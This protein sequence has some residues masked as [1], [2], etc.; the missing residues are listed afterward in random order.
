MA[1]IKG[2]TKTIDNT[3]KK[4]LSSNVIIGWSNKHSDEGILIKIT[5][6]GNYEI[7][8]TL[9]NDFGVTSNLKQSQKNV[10]K[11]MKAHPKG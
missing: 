11:Y 2:W 8:D 7:V 9:G 1:R 4:I 6:R 5:N 3:N 10:I